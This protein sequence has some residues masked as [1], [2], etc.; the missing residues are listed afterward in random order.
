MKIA[1]GV[2]CS[3][4]VC[5]HVAVT[6]RA[7]CPNHL[8]CVPLVAIPPPKPAPLLI[9]SHVSAELALLPTRGAVSASHVA[10]RA[11]LA[12][13]GPIAYV[14]ARVAERLGSVTF[15]LDLRRNSDAG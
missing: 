5:A 4:V 10:G 1:P 3:R 15:S 14:V 9:L 11:D 6:C 2:G 13:D 12:D 7:N 8:G